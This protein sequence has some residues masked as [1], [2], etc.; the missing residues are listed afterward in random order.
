[1][2]FRFKAVS[3]GETE[4][5]VESLVGSFGAS[6]GFNGGVVGRVLVEDVVGQKREQATSAQAFPRD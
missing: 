1:M 5:V 6:V 2:A 4:E 3:E